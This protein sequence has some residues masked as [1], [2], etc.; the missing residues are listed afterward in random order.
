M[1]VRVVAYYIHADGSGTS[2]PESTRLVVLTDPCTGRLLAIVD[3]HWNYSVR[4]SAAAVIGAKYLARRDSRIVGIVGAG[5][6]ARTGLMAL[7]ATFAVTSVRVTSRTPASFER[8]AR[9][10]SVS[11]GLSV[12]PRKTIQEVC[13]GADII[14]IATTN[15]SPLVKQAW[16]APGTCLVTVGNDEVDHALY[17]AVDKVVVDDVEEVG[18]MLRPVVE[19][20]HMAEDGIYSAIWEIVAGRKPGRERP[21]ERVLIKT[22]GLVPQDVA[23]AYHAY[24]RATEMNLGVPLIG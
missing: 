19:E 15:R 8:F 23:V 17:G 12:E 11:L 4:T 16:V 1:G 21:D 2:A 3:E 5:N 13:E 9:E 22:V 6:L 20:G 10:M 14:F 18:Q 24:T 7:C